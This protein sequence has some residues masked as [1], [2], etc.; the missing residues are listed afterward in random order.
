MSANENLPVTTDSTECVIASSG[1]VSTAVDLHGHNLVGCVMPAAFTGTAITFQG[2]QEGTTFTDLYDTAGSALSITV[3][4]DRF[5][6]FTPSDFAG[7]RFIKLVSGSS[8]GAE[9]TLTLI[10]RAL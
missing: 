7:V 9:R 3:A 8:E 5:I 10:H 6:L 1:T 4:A 2:S